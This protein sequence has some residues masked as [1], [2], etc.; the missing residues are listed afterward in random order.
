MK[1]YFKEPTNQSCECESQYFEG[2]N[3]IT[4]LKAASLDEQISVL[5]RLVQIKVQEKKF[6]LDIKSL[7]W[8]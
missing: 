7:L 1:S 3:L 4:Q 5:F 6:I 2:I 8:I